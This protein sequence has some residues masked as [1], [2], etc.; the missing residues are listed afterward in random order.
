MKKLYL[1]LINSLFFVSLYSAMIEQ[2]KYLDELDIEEKAISSKESK[3]AMTKL[4][5]K[6]IIAIRSLKNGGYIYTKSD[7]NDQIVKT[8]KKEDSATFLA[9]TMITPPETQFIIIKDKKNEFIYLKS[10]LME[11]KVLTCNNTNVEFKEFKPTDES[12]QWIIESGQGLNQI[13]LKN[14]MSNKYLSIEKEDSEE[15]KTV[16]PTP[17]VGKKEPEPCM[18]CTLKEQPE[19]SELFKIVILD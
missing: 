1:L 12:Q 8:L 6:T 10:I 13:Y 7:R 4:K 18:Q 16:D 3:N 11:G 15:R 2:P 17:V 14:K 19:R 5:N 9:F